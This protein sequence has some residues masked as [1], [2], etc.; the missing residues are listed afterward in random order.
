MHTDYQCDKIN[1]EVVR[2]I[3]TELKENNFWITTSEEVHKWFLVKEQLEVKT[4]QRGS[5]RIAVTI[6]NPGISVASNVI[7][8]VDLNIK[9]DNI[10]I[11]SEVIGRR[12]AA[13]SH[14]RGS[15]IINLYIDDLQPNE[16]R[17]I[18]IDIDQILS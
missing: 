3:I 15:E 2:D 6:S 16:V 9:A 11:E 12:G 18:Y 1:V 7:I 13:F 17:T 14:Q 5:S 4:E 10:S 8:C